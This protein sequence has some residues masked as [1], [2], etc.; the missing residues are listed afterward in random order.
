[1]KTVATKFVRAYGKRGLLAAIAV[2]SALVSAKCGWGH[3]GPVGFFDG[4]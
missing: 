1:V 4:G 2:V 3:H